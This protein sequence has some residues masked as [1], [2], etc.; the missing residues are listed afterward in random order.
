[1]YKP[2]ECVEI[3]Q[4]QIRIVPGNHH[5]KAIS[6]SLIYAIQ[7]SFPSI[8]RMKDEE[9]GDFLDYFDEYSFAPK[10][11]TFLTKAFYDEFMILGGDTEMLRHPSRYKELTINTHLVYVF[12]DA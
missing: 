11:K 5:K 8:C 3:N 9:C 1:M 12:F 2:V 4:N 6:G 10:H 7:S